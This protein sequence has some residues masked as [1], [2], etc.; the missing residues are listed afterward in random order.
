[1][2]PKFWK[3]LITNGNGSETRFVA[4]QDREW[5]ERELE[6]DPSLLSYRAKPQFQPSMFRRPAEGVLQRLRRARAQ[7]QKGR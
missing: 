3:Y 6:D 2:T 5:A 1:M 4:E 7:Q